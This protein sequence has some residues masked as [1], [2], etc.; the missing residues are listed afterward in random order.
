MVIPGLAKDNNP[1]LDWPN[2]L[3]TANAA[4]TACR[5]NNS[6]RQFYQIEEL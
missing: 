6:N 3:I 1:A 5:S 4:V 2:T